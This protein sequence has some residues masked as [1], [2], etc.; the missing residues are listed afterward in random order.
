[1]QLLHRPSASLPFRLRLGVE[2]L[3]PRLRIG[4]GQI[5]LRLHF[6]AGLIECSLQ[7]VP[8][9]LG[10]SILCFP[11]Q[12]GSLRPLLGPIS[13]CFSLVPVVLGLVC[14]VVGVTGTKQKTQRN[15]RLS[16]TAVC[17]WGGRGRQILEISLS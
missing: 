9:L 15:Q 5:E 3:E 17:A 11:C 14:P 12:I 16:Q 2:L 1:M 13:V 4:A 7:Q 10:A 8:S 6:L